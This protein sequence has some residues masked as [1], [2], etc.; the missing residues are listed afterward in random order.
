MEH[1][2]W[3][4]YRYAME[5][6]TVNLSTGKGEGGEA[7]GDTLRN[8]ELVWGSKKDDTF[9]ASE[10]VD[11]IHGDEGSDTISYEAS[12][13]GVTVNLFSD[14]PNDGSAATPFD[15]TPSL[16]DLGG[17][18]AAT[19][20]PDSTLRAAIPMETTADDGTVSN[21]G[22]NKGDGNTAAGD[23]IGGIENV[24]G[25]AHDDD[26]TGDA[27]ANTLKGMGDDDDLSGVGGDDKLYGGAGGDDLMGGADSD[28]LNGGAGNDDLN[29]DGTETAAVDTFVFSPDDGRGVDVIED[30]D[31]ATTS[32]PTTVDTDDKIDLTA[33]DLDVATLKTLISERAG[34]IIIDLTDKGGGTIILSGISDLDVLDKEANETGAE[35]DDI[36]TLKADERAIDLNGDGDYNDSWDNNNGLTGGTGGA[37][38]TF[39][40]L[41][42]D[43]AVGGGDDFDINRDGKLEAA[44]T[45]NELAMGL[46]LDKDGTIEDA[47]FT[48]AVFNEADGIFIL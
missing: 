45:L 37:P 27:M 3:A 30:L 35:G 36:D 6:V 16:G 19:T 43:G 28:V 15:D 10:D 9:I 17:G 2:D 42:T 46:D 44:A 34:D 29:G 11:R 1:I 31:A 5:G 33:F 40:E 48:G 20:N 47:D 39:N 23:Y 4:V 14:Q 18:A 24:T 8:I 12:E 41:G 13:T 26:L 25:S 22:I 7:M 21:A 38:S 32:D